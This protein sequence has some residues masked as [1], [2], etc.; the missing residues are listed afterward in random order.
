[1]IPA[2]IA[3]TNTTKGSASYVGVSINAGASVANWGW[4]VN[5]GAIAECGRPTTKK[6]GA[7]PLL[8]LSGSKVAPGA[9]VAAHVYFVVGDF[10]TSANP[11]G[12]SSLL[13]TPLVIT[14]KWAIVS[15]AVAA[16]V[17]TGP[18]ATHVTSGPLAKS[19]VFSLSGKTPS[20]P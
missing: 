6:G 10:Y 5:L 8:I 9:T 4:Q 15:K 12:N 1:M 18:G 3:L 16:D 13:D 14:G 2:T 20:T 19:W 11:S 17:L 7:G